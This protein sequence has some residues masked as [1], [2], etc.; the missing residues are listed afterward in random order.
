MI[1][2]LRRNQIIR[3]LETRDDHLPQPIR[4]E[5]SPAGFIHNTQVRE[6][7][8][9][10]FGE[11]PGKVGCETC[12]SSG[13]IEYIRERD[14]YAVEKVQPY[15]MTG[16]RHE[17]RRERDNE[18]RRLEAQTSPP[19]TSAAD[20]LAY[21]NAHPEPWEIARA[22]K[23]R[24]YDYPA[25]HN[26]LELLRDRDEGAYKL[27]HACHVYQWLETS[28]VMEHAIERG[29][30]F[31]DQRMPDV[32]RA[33]GDQAPDPA[34]AKDS[35]RYGKRPEHEAARERRTTR[36]LRAHFAWG[37]STEEIAQHESLTRRRVQQLIA[38]HALEQVAVASGPAA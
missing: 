24:D 31:I 20:E 23:W 16:D 27:L 4:R 22:R 18:L 33:P 17:K 30:S 15:G 19:W 1:D 5:H 9:D 34:L 2:S 36:V 3:L 7:C 13:Y 32:I 21:A 25:L 11:N 12:K 14:P 37:W 38:E 8:P 28:A 29:L 26:A 6:T 10:C 35:L